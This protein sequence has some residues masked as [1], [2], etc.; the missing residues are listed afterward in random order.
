MA[1]ASQRRS[2]SSPTTCR[3]SER[4]RAVHH[5]H[6]HVVVRERRD[7]REPG[8]R[9]GAAPR[10]RW[11]ARGRSLCATSR[12]SRP[13]PPPPVSRRS[14]RGAPI[15]W[16]PTPP[17]GSPCSRRRRDRR[18]R[19]GNAASARPTSCLRCRLPSSIDRLG[20]E[21]PDVGH[22]FDSAADKD[23]WSDPRPSRVG[24]LQARQ[25]E[26]VVATSGEAAMLAWSER[27][28]AISPAFTV[29]AVQTPRCRT[30]CASTSSRPATTSPTPSTS[31][32]THVRPTTRA[33]SRTPL[34]GHRRRE[35]RLDYNRGIDQPRRRDPRR[36][37]AARGEARS[38]LLDGRLL[39]RR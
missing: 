32:G 8:R 30:P 27:P 16:L 12:A 24:R 28:R 18:A 14:P 31:S 33:R 23:L 9:L 2:S 3:P 7:G 11:S 17:R 26:P 13:R 39:R 15:V 20:C 37:R 6:R 38:D 1:P 25:D 10:H 21:A 22:M 19:G 34:G 35:V 4:R 5:R 29:K 36:G